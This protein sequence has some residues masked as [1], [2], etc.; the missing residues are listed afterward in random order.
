MKLKKIAS[1]ALAGI[2]AVSM[3]AG[4]NG[5]GGTTTPV[6][7][8]VTGQSSIVSIVNSGIVGNAAGISFKYDSSL[9]NTLEMLV[10]KS[11]AD[12][13]A[14]DLRD[15]LM[16][17][18]DY[19]KVTGPSDGGNFHQ[20]DLNYAAERTVDAVKVF[21]MSGKSMDATYAAY[22]M[23]SNIAKVVNELEKSTALNSAVCNFTYE[24]ANVCMVEVEVDGNNYYFVAVTLTS[25]GEIQS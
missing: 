23:A 6:T 7:D 24:N 1:L 13:N 14:D 21:K 11:G 5:N 18:L 15:D 9:A 19:D 16:D 3:L 12:A 8:D 20:N 2:M 17:E 22:Q 25:V 4:C 10:R